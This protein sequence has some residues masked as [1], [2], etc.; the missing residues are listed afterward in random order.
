MLNI[1]P[2]TSDSPSAVSFLSRRKIVRDTR[3]GGAWEDHLSVGTRP[4]YILQAPGGSP[5]FYSSGLRN[6]DVH[7]SSRHHRVGID[8]AYLRTL[9]MVLL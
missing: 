4:F 7:L 9:R 8:C 6:T 2:L 5:Q 3:A 1:Q